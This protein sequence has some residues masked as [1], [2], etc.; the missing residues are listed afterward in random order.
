MTKTTDKLTSIEGKGVPNL[1][2]EA[3]RRMSEDFPHLV[4]SVKFIAKLQREK[5]LAL[6]SE[7]FT[8]EEAIELSKTILTT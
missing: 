4:A 8:N 1:S 7:G 3:L 6:K 5:F 2:A